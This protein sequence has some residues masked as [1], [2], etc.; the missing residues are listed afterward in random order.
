[1]THILKAEQ[2]S[3]FRGERCL[4]DSI[5]F[6]LASG[7]LL[8]LRGPNGSGKTSLLRGLCGLLEFEDGKIL[9]DDVDISRDRQS[10]RARFAWYGHKTGFKLDL[11]AEENLAFESTLRAP[12][13]LAIRDAIDRLGLNRQRKLPVRSLSAGQQRRASLAR[14]LLSGVKVWV[15]DEPFTNLDADG[16]A[17]VEE[18]VAEHVAGG[19]MAIVATHHDMLAGGNVKTLEIGR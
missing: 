16:R 19:G 3:L 9:W 7:E 15:I 17:L 5:G 12:S 18:L 2:L 8:L 10:F 1:M 11:T 14:L 4:F 6:A 13:G